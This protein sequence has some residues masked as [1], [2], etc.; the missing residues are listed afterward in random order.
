MNKL[1]TFILIIISVGYFSCE[2]LEN[3]GYYDYYGYS[4]ESSQLLLGKD[5]YITGMTCDSS[6]LTG[7][8]DTRPFLSSPDEFTSCDSLFYILD[9]PLHI[10]H[11]SFVPDD[12]DYDYLWL[13]SNNV[14]ELILTLFSINETTLQRTPFIFNIFELSEDRMVMLLRDS[15]VFPEHNLCWVTLEPR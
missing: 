5:W 1:L 8:F 13:E 11:W 2:G 15:P 10:C 7:D 14:G 12:S 9:F 6:N 4:N 3:Y